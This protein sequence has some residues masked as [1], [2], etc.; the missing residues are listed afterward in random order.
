MPPI[1]DT[2]GG[3]SGFLAYALWHVYRYFPF[4]GTWD[5][6]LLVFALAGLVR[7]LFLPYLWKGVRADMKIFSEGRVLSGSEDSRQDVWPV[8]W[9]MA[10]MWLLVW[11]FHTPAGRTFLEGR[12]WLSA[13]PPSE[14]DRGLVWLSITAHAALTVSF[15]GIG[16]AIEGKYKSL[17]PGRSQPYPDRSLLS[18]FCGGG[19]IV[20]RMQDGSLPVSAVFPPTWFDVLLIFLAHLCYWYWSIVSL[21]VMLSFTVAGLL[22]EAARMC[23]VYVLH[24]KTFG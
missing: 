19:A 9:D 2:G 15:G 20:K 12:A 10:C 18:L 24:K 3:L 1:P 11:F 17:A 7:V 6:L 21:C 22:T 8:L 16:S 5:W 4:S 13:A 23:F 14:V